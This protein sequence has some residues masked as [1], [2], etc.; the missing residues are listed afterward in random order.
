M[1]YVYI[2]KIPSTY[3]QLVDGIQQSMCLLGRLDR[4]LFMGI[5]YIRKNIS[6]E[7]KNIRNLFG[8]CKIVLTLYGKW[9]VHS[10]YE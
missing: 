3:L 9:S 4:P 2:S 1:G 6:W 8:Y 10:L 5:P 7:L